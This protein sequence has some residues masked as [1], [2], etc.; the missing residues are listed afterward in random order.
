MSITRKAGA[1]A[2]VYGDRT[3]K[4]WAAYYEVWGK[5]SPSTRTIC[6]HYAKCKKEGKTD[7]EIIAEQ[8]RLWIEGTAED[9]KTLS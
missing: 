9:G 5:R 8:K 6:A 2:T 7:N 4:G 1:P 3:F